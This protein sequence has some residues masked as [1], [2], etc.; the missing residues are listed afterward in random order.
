MNAISPPAGD[1]GASVVRAMGLS[2]G[3]AGTPA[4]QDIDLAVHAGE[5]VVLLGANGAGKSTTLL[6]LAGELTPMAGS[7]EVLGLGARRGLDYRARRGLGYLT[8]GRCVF[9]ELTGWE[10]LRLG[11]GPAERALEFFPELEPHLAKRAGLLSGGQQQMLALG[12]ILAA[13]P[14]LVLADELSLGLAP[15]IVRRLLAVLRAAADGGTAVVLVEQHV[16]QALGIADRG[17]V[18]HRGRVVMSGSG[19]ELRARA[20]EIA[21]HYISGEA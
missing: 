11:R 1:T 20:S 13:R 8:E 5:V 16:H 18:L 6:T 21:A 19:A 3:Y 4:V 2:S 7:V 9:M 17:Y 12:R 14:R 10:N 15:I